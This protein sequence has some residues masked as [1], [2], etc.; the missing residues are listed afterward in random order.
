MPIP[1]SFTVATCTLGRAHDYF[2]HINY[3]VCLF[4][5]IDVRSCKYNL[6]H[7][8][9]QAHCFFIINDHHMPIPN[10]FCGYLHSRNIQSCAKKKRKTG[11]YVVKWP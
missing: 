5:S 6:C 3:I 11:L 7:P 10:S 1:N 4:V 9:D 8:Q 2:S